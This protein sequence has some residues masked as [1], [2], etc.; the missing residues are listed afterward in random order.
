MSKRFYKS[1]DKK[2]SGVCG[3]IAD[4]FNWD[5]TIVRVLWAVLTLCTSGFPGILIYIVLALVMPNRPSSDADW[6][7]MKRA[8]DYKPSDDKEFNSYFDKDK[9]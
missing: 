8:N 6:D 7:N 9:K 1:S 4:Y 5:P 2:I 3:G